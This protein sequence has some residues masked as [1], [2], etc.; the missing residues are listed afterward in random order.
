MDSDRFGR[1]WEGDEREAGYESYPSNASAEKELA[2]GHFG[3]I[4]RTGRWKVKE[5]EA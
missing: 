4:T 1:V 3:Q 2:P 5:S